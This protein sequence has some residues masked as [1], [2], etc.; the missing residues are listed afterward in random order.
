MTNN[1]LLIPFILGSLVACTSDKTKN[2]SET[3]EPSSEP[4]TIDTN[5][6]SSEPFEGPVSG[7]FLSYYQ[8]VDLNNP[9]SYASGFAMFI[10]PGHSYHFISLCVF[11]SICDDLSLDEVIDVNLTTMYDFESYM[12]YY[13]GDISFG[14]SSMSTSVFEENY[15]LSIYNTAS[16]FG[17]APETGYGVELPEGDAF[18]S[19]YSGTADVTTSA[20]IELTSVDPAV[21]FISGTGFGGGLLPSERSVELTWT[22][23]SG[24]ELYLRVDDGINSYIV[25]TEDDGSYTIDFDAL[26]MTSDGFVSIS[27]LRIVAESLDVNG[28]DI[29]VTSLVR[30]DV[31]AYLTSQEVVNNPPTDLGDTC[32]DIGDAVSTGEYAFGGEITSSWNDDVNITCILPGAEESFGSIGADAWVKIDLN[33]NETLVANYSL[34]RADG[35]LYLTDSCSTTPDC[36]SLS[37]EVGNVPETVIYTN[38][39]DSAS[40]YLG[41]DLWESPDGSTPT[42]LPE[43]YLLDIWIGT[44]SEAPMVDTCDEAIAANPLTTGTYYY[45]GSFTGFNNDLDSEGAW[46]GYEHIGPDSLIPVTIAAGETIEVSFTLEENDAVLYLIDDCSSA[47]GEASAASD[48]TLNGQEEAFSYTNTSGAPETLYIGFDLWESSDAPAVDNDGYFAII[49]IK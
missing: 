32:D 39:G 16:D 49:S 33:T 48:N 41:L 40:F 44:I 30:Q 36:L 34:G 28:Q 6:P 9:E 42:S 19:G 15:G 5:S 1:I 8:Q 24:S 7:S 22:A 18:G 12:P 38:T 43:A 27:M 47:D 20:S 45:S 29:E 3:T 2:T 35:V 25:K 21:D 4:S 46:T 17:F 37:D 14:G 31:F 10:D 23:S 13:V 11:E 26:G